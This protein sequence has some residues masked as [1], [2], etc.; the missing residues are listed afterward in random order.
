MIQDII[1][2]KTYFF[3]LPYFLS[4]SFNYVNTLRQNK[5][6]TLR[7]ADPQLTPSC[8]PADPQLT[9]SWPTELA[10]RRF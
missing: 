6:I 8:P 10:A 7:A 4:N 2:A 5:V 9:P 3:L 1:S